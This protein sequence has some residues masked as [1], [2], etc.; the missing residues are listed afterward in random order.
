MVTTL[1]LLAIAATGI[2]NPTMHA[3][4]AQPLQDPMR[5]VTEITRTS[6]TLQYFTEQPCE[7]RVQVRQSDLPMT[8]WRPKNLKK[9]PWA[10][11]AKMR[12]VTGSNA[13]TTYHVVN[14][15]GLEPGKR[16]FYRIFDPAAKPTPEEANWGAATPWRREFAVSTQ[17]PKGFKTIIHL[18]VKVLIMPNV[19]NVESAHDEN[20]MLVPPPPKL[21]DAEI[22]RI[23]QEFAI[24]SRYYWGNNG[25][26]FWVDYHIQID[27]RWQRWGPEP[28]NVDKAYKGWPMCRSYGGADFVG[29][30]GGDFTIVDT[31]NPIK[32]GKDPVNEEKPY[33][34][35]VEQSFPRKWD[36]KTKKWVFYGSGGGTFGVDG[37][38][39][40]VPGR[41]QFLGG[42]DTAWLVAH[43]YHHQME[44]LG[45]FSLSNREDDRITFNHPDF[46][47]RVRREDGAWDEVT[48]SSANPT[49]D[50]W[51]CMSYSD[52]TLSD[53][54]WLRMYFGETLIVKDQDEDGVPDDDAR[55]PLDE[56]RFGSDP[57]KPKT[58]GQMGDLQKAMLSTWVPAVL[59]Y[60]FDKP[61]FQGKKPNP[62]SVDSDGDGIPD[63]LDPWPLYPWKPFVWP[64]TANVDGRADE[65]SDVPLAGEKNEGGVHL[66]YKQGH[67]EEA[68]Y[69]AFRVKGP[70][71]RI[72]ICL[73]GEGN[74]VFTYGRVGV[75]YITFTKGEFVSAKVEGGKM[76]ALNYKTGTSPDGSE[77]IEFSIPNRGDGQWYWWR[78]G[79]PV[80]MFIDVT[81][82]KN[83]TYSVYEPYHMFYC[84]MM[85]P[86]GRR[87]MPSGAP[88]ELTAAESTYVLKPGDPKLKLIGKGW[89]LV[90]GAYRY[91]PGEDCTALVDGL[92]ATEFDVWV[93]FEANQDAVLGAFVPGT[94]ELNPGNDYIAFLGGYANTVTRFR[95][96]GREE[97]DGD[98]MLSPGKHTMQFSRRA[99]RVWML[100]D[101]KPVITAVD[102][103][104]QRVVDRIGMIGCGD[105]QQ[106]LHEMRVKVN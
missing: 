50:H 82:Q 29:P 92:N 79:R 17:A 4:D 76:G 78:G 32:A 57:A 65:W 18:P 96:Y 81:D 63:T 7:T 33:A 84:L 93:S 100:V 37:F 11:K 31:K 64:V 90:D 8:A 47:R 97:A 71:K 80:G 2:G 77:V 20:G 98:V 16:Y 30:G 35:Q 43:E 41:S 48:W 86:T 87:P 12:V 88:A 101:G 68:Y 38:P 59:Q 53:A 49:G 103:D 67:D 24:A 102:P 14:V 105:G 21:T 39:Q 85:E 42:S 6:F 19:V 62:R 91:S 61:A 9:N 73:D 22:A 74:G 26:R 40:G 58:D 3:P 44:S 106:V 95:L 66:W 51:D 13:S 34:G 10:D 69:G 60:T 15:S 75:Y 89:N 23:K 104:P 1:A 25:M 55:L 28:K 83:A 46:R 27:D 94:K 45:A 99:G 56:K 54:Q 70:W 52:R 72:Q 5:P 36:S